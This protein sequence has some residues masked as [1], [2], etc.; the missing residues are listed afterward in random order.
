MLSALY[1]QNALTSDTRTPLQIMPPPA[2]YKPVIDPAKK[3]MATPTPMMTPF[4]AIPEENTQLKKDMPA[5]LE[6]LPDMKPEDMQ[7]FSKLL[8]VGSFLSASGVQQGAS[9]MPQA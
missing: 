1:H 3:L 4:Y 7:Y 6:G 9:H 5:E 8:Q 2:S